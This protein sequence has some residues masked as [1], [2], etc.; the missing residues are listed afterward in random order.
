VLDDAQQ[1]DIVAAAGELQIEAYRSVI[2]ES[3]K[4]KS[5]DGELKWKRKRKKQVETEVPFGERR[6]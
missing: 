1:V 4:P 3:S 5:V 6:V 2:K